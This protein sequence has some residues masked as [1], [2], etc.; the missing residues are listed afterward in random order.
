MSHDEL[1][2]SLAETG[3]IMAERTRY[4]AEQVH[5]MRELL[6]LQNGR[7]AE[8]ERWRSYTTGGLAVLLAVNLPVLLILLRHY[9][10][11]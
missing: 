7:I 6:R 2:S 3:T 9:I 1:L 4:I 11:T 5:E 10:T 8:L